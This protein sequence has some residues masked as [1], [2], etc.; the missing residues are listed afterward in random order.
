MPA[1]FLG[2]H[3]SGWI[4]APVMTWLMRVHS[5]TGGGGTLSHPRGGVDFAI[6]LI[7]NFL[8]VNVVTGFYMRSEMAPEWRFSRVKWLQTW[9]KRPKEVRDDARNF[10]TR[11]KVVPCYKPGV[12]SGFFNKV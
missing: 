10:S 2:Q 6:D 4:I 5:G 7:C 8:K 11:L 12:G 9:R 3:E 1:E